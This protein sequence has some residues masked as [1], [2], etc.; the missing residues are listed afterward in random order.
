M[1][2]GESDWLEEF[3]YEVEAVP[4]TA[5]EWMFVGKLIFCYFSLI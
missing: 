1:G 4:G 5:Q 2:S 3:R